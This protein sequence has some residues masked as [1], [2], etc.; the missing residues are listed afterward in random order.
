MSQVSHFLL[1]HLS[2]STFLRRFY[3]CSP[4]CSA[5]IFSFIVFSPLF[6]GTYASLSFSFVSTDTCSCERGCSEL[7][8]K[9]TVL[10]SLRNLTILV[11]LLLLFAVCFCYS[12][13]IYW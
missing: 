13:S 6:G 9:K 7:G 1:Q 3:S 12:A 11:F 5:F 10:M 8:S 4:H 2:L